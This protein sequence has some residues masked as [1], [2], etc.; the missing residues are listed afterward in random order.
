[1]AKI[2]DIHDESTSFVREAHR[3]C[4]DLQ[5]PDPAVYWSDFF[6]SIL[7]AYGALW[8]YLRAQTLS[9]VHGAALIVCGLALY[10]A[11]VFTHEINHQRSRIKGFAFVW[12]VLC[13]I[14]SLVPSFLY[15]DHQGHHSAQAYGTW[16]DPEYLLQTSRW[17]GRIAVFLLMPAIYPVMAAVR[18]LVLT[19]LAVLSRRLD[20]IIWTHAS[21]LYVMNEFYRREYG[22]QARTRA[23][24]AQEAACSIWAWTFLVLVLQGHISTGTMWRLYSVSL[25]WI[26]LN[27]VRTLVAHRY[28]G[29]SDASMSYLD[30]VIDTNTFDRGRWLPH[31]WAPLGLRY[32]A[33][34]HLLPSMPYHAMGR[35]HRRL[36]D[37]LPPDSP[38][39]RTLRSGLWPALMS[40]ARNQAPQKTS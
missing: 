1:M 40:L 2:G 7:L 17:R 8:L 35:A 6:A 30:Q 38:Y 11:V 33:L 10:R 3:V 27:Q 24:W 25:F 5:D 31:L 37:R 4:R 14:P 32:H 16:A 29:R 18:F 19:P 12:N 9:A 26:A 34:H 39:R 28:T 23:R 15:G 13:G 36:L 21:S 22:G 20:R